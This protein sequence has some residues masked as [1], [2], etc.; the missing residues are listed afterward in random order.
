MTLGNI[1]GGRRGG[2]QEPVVLVIDFHHARGPEI[3]F[4][5][6]DG[7]ENPVD[8]NDLSLLPFMAMSDGSHASTEDYSYFTLRSSA[9]TNSGP[10]KSLFGISCTRQLDSKLL[11]NRPPEVTR[12]TVQKAVVV[13]TD[14][15]KH[16][17]QLREKLSVITSAWFAQRDFTDTDILK[18]FRESLTISL[19]S[20][21]AQK[22]EYLGLSLRE[23]IH[24]FKYQTLV[25]FKCLLLQPKM[26]FFGTRC[27][28]LCMIQFS[29]ISLIPGLVH[30]LQDCA[31]P[32][33]DSYAETVVKPTSLKTS[34]R[35]SLL[36]YMGLPLQIFGKGSI[37][38]PYTP[39]Q[40]LDMLADSGTKS[41]VVGSTNSLL[42]QQKDRY[43]DVLINLDEDTISIMSPSLRSAATLSVADRR[44]IDFLTQTINETW[45]EAHPERPK[46]HG[47]FG[48]EEFI[49]LQFEEYLLALLSCVK[50]QEE[51][52]SPGLGIQKQSTNQPQASDV[53]GN[54]A[55]E[56]NLEFLALWKTT[57]NYT[58]FN[59]LTSDALLYSIVEPRHP[60][61][62]GLT[63]DDVSRR[64]SQQVADLH[65]DEKVRGGREVLNK[66]LATG[67]KKVSTAF[68]SFWTDFEAMREAQRKRNEERAQASG[69][70]A[71]STGNETGS[72]LASPRASTSNSPPPSS[73]WF[74]ARRNQSSADQ[75]NTQPAATS[76][77]NT[78]SQRAGA[79][80]S[81]W[82]T[83]AAERRKEWQEKKAESNSPPASIT[84]QSTTTLASHPEKPEPDRGR[85]SLQISREN[86]TASKLGR[87]MSRK[88]RWSSIL[89][90]KE[91]QESDL[92]FENGV[93]IVTVPSRSPTIASVNNSQPELSSS[94]SQD[95]NPATSKSTDAE[96]S[97][98]TAPATDPT[99]TAENPTPLTP[100]D[101]PETKPAPTADIPDPSPPDH[102]DT[103]K[104]VPPNEATNNTPALDPT[105][106]KNK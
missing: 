16:F 102:A 74:F 93:E 106:T 24:E 75:T 91:E 96:E 48:S 65:L 52:T 15:P 66:H 34:E 46:T 83:W 11:Y 101:V 30:N 70:E 47:Y 8:E 6:N 64:I 78:A 99:P 62:G 51:Q 79:Y 22:D 69:A 5:F 3:E 28:R 32:A 80:L 71:S 1:D 25:L 19:N 86:S 94:D 54:P 89:R 90:K 53:E 88:K 21:E 38:G 72:P 58:L 103:P 100:A 29:L 43:S 10:P 105:T 17:G 36:A 87:S 9:T 49:R 26:L 84:S 12:S 4:C 95:P 20:E 18:K 50:Y 97:S 35:S 68:N 81:S 14:K 61:A 42:L 2:S 56:F 63:I 60:C 59:R 82:G 27:E 33:F 45:D 55:H 37:F 73:P 57:P 67:H 77:A 13:L 98:S 85:I 104:E 76:N 92:N 44:W 41:Y 7:G 23:M 31:D 40:Q 39:L